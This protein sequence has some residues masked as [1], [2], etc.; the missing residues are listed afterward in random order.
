MD[1]SFQSE[2]L[3]LSPEFEPP[4]GTH[5]GPT[6]PTH[7]DVPPQAKTA[8]KQFCDALGLKDMIPRK[9]LA[10]W[11]TDTLRKKGANARKLRKTVYKIMAPHY[12]EA[13]EKVD[14]YRD[15]SSVWTAE[16][17]T[18]FVSIM[19]SFADSY[20]DAEDSKDREAILAIV[21]PVLS[22]N[23]IVAVIPGLTRYRF[24]SAR[25]FPAIVNRKEEQTS[26]KRNRYSYFAVRTFVQ[27]I[28]R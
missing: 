8:F 22:Y 16:H 20:H 28:T 11:Q 3:P 25:R 7:P 12:E 18:K 13:L 27:F 15:S 23:E 26:A 24:T 10:A 19:E 4:R 2:N 21:A 14:I 1:Y 6:V 17:S 5:H 9:P